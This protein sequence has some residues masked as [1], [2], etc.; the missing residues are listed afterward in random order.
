MKTC[1]HSSPDGRYTLMVA[2]AGSQTSPHYTTSHPRRQQ[3]SWSPSWNTKTRRRE[4]CVSLWKPNSQGLFLVS[5][6]YL[7]RN[8]TFISGTSVCETKARFTPLNHHS[9]T[10]RKNKS[11]H[12]VG[13]HSRHVY[14]LYEILDVVRSCLRLCLTKS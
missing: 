14:L 6:F 3:S 12:A 7:C 2:A 5:T 1:R 9:I 11:K 4:N 13:P 8:F 10:S